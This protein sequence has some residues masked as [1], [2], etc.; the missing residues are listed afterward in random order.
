MSFVV[1]SFLWS[2]EGLRR[3]NEVCLKYG[4]QSVPKKYVLNLNNFAEREGYHLLFSDDYRRGEEKL[5]INA[6]TELIRRAVSRLLTA[7]SDIR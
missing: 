1:W 5:I 3:R 2:K 6:N 4:I 7:R